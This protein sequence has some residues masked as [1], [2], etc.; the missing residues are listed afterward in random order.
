[1][2]KKH[3]L[4]GQPKSRTFP[5]ENSGLEERVE[6]GAVTSPHVDAVRGTNRVEIYAIRQ[7]QAGEE[8][9]PEVLIR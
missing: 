7:P 9:V 5:T 4:T 1:M 6:G 8:R 3:T 2:S